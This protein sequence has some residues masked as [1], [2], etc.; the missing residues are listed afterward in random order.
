MP[1]LEAD[2]ALPSGDERRH[3]TVHK[4]LAMLEKH[5]DR[6]PSPWVSP[7]FRVRLLFPRRSLCSGPSPSSAVVLGTTALT[8]STLACARRPPRRTWN[9]PTSGSERLHRAWSG[10]RPVLS[11]CV[12]SSSSRA[13]VA[14]VRRGRSSRAFVVGVRRGR[15]SSCG[16]SSS[17]P[18]SSASSPSS[19][20][21][22]AHPNAQHPRRRLIGEGIVSGRLLV[23]ERRSY[24]AFLRVLDEREISDEL[25][26]AT[27]RN[28][29]HV[30][31]AGDVDAS[32]RVYEGIAR[33]ARRNLE[34]RLKF[35]GMVCSCRK[36]AVLEHLPVDVVCRLLVPVLEDA[37]AA[38]TGD[39]THGGRDRDRARGRDHGI[40]TGTERDADRKLLARDVF[41]SIVDAVG[42]DRAL[43]GYNAA[44][45]RRAG[46][47]RDRRARRA[48]AGASV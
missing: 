10:T 9:T 16:S 34:Q 31:C 35:V 19:S 48:G 29:F 25:A 33:N 32:V 12:I 39:G 43:R 8:R 11:F 46:R 21:S 6:I 41:N 47:Q 5:A 22:H 27:L 30:L 26:K 2:A 37:A 15:S 24:E 1:M 45:E 17:S 40:G 4:G 20:D 36:E 44:K 7:V 18:S 28:L 3:L 13:F 42:H 38:S 14:G 23:D